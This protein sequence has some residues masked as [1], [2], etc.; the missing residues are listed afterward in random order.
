MIKKDLNLKSL[1]EDNQIYCDKV[2]RYFKDMLYCKNFLKRILHLYTLYILMD[3]SLNN[4]STGHYTLKINN[5]TQVI[6]CSQE[7][8]PGISC[9][10]LAH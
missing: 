6:S 4:L 9:I 8:V 3:A 7:C 10:C 5:S 1:L 2:S